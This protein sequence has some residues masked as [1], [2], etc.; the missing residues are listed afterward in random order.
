LVKAD[1][2]Y[3]RAVRRKK[4]PHQYYDKLNHTNIDIIILDIIENTSELEHT[5]TERQKGKIEDEKSN[6]SLKRLNG[7]E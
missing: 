5:D 3:V 6:Q 2:N 1:A 7:G 4:E